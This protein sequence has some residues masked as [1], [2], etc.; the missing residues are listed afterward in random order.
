MEGKRKRSRGADGRSRGSKHHSSTSKRGALGSTRP[1][2][3]CLTQISCEEKQL[4][5]TKDKKRQA[6]GSRVVAE[7]ERQ[8]KDDAEVEVIETT[9]Q[10]R[11]QRRG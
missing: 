9:E 4:E 8:L 1:M 7:L 5:E 10:S 11:E 2:L 3:R 6:M